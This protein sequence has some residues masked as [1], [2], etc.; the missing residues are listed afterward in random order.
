MS[1]VREPAPR[2]AVLR[3]PS[4]TKTLSSNLDSAF[5]F[6]SSDWRL[7]D[8]HTQAF[9]VFIPLLDFLMWPPPCKSTKATTDRPGFKS[10]MSHYLAGAGAGGGIGRDLMPEIHDPSH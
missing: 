4:I 9:F 6:L 1:H 8:I 3:C 5:G 2:M 10:L 7:S